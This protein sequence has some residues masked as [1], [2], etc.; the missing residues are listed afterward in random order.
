MIR[1][2]LI[3]YD[4]P[5]KK[6]EHATKIQSIAK[7][8][9]QAIKFPP[10]CAKKVSFID[11]LLYSFTCQNAPSVGRQIPKPPKHT[12]RPTIIGFA[13]VEASIGAINVPVVTNAVAD[14]PSAAF[15]NTD[16]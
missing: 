14:D 16:K 6:P 8:A 4:N 13:P 2:K 3:G 12:A 15:N 7:P 9:K 1:I 10:V 5:G 11:R